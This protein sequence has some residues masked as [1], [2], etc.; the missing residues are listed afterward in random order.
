[1]NEEL[2]TVIKQSLLKTQKTFSIPTT[3]NLASLEKIWNHVVLNTPEIFYVDGYRY[4]LTNKN[5]LISPNYKYDINAIKDIR[6]KCT[7]Q[8][9]YIL[10]I[11]KRETTDYSKVLKVHDVL[12]KNLKY[13]ISDDFELHTIVAPLTRKQAVCDGFSKTFKYV[14]EKLG[15]DCR[16]VVGTAWNPGSSK[17]ELDNT[18]DNLEISQCN[19]VLEYYTQKHQ[20]KNFDSYFSNT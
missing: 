19:I 1:M 20:V 4:C 3:V 18:D 11:A 16:V 14:L 7:E 15:I 5:C 9:E 6:I 8:A 10:N 13:E 2:K 12:C 17:S